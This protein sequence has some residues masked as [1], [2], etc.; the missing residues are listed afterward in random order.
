[1]SEELVCPVTGWDLTRCRFCGLPLIEGYWD[2]TNPD[3]GARMRVCGPCGLKATQ[4]GCMFPDE[5]P[6]YRPE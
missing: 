5:Q 1:M 4:G 2:L 6:E 3:S